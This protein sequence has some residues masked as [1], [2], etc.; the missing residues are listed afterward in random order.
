MERSEEKRQFCLK[1]V[2]IIKKYLEEKPETDSNLKEIL[3]ISKGAWEV[4]ASS[5]GD[6]PY[7]D[8]GSESQRLYGE[9]MLARMEKELSK[10]MANKKDES[11]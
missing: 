5:H 9:T 3:R 1:Q 7:A 8:I 6:S 2:E 11:Y 10:L 4:L